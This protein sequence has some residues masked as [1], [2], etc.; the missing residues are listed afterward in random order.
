MG[1]LRRIGA[2]LLSIAQRMN[3][4]NRTQIWGAIALFWIGSLIVSILVGVFWMNA[5]VRNIVANLVADLL[6]AAVIFIAV[7]LIFG[8]SRRQ[9]ERTEAISKAMYMLGSEIT[10]NKK[11]LE[12]I[13]GDFEKGW[14]PAPDPKLETENWELFVQGP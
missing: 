1:V 3:P 12:R 4:Q 13:I 11:E 7:D 10:M 2:L 8:F 5:L 14:T 9:E 6:V